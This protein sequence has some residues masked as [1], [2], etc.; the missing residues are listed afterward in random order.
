[1]HVLQGSAGLHHVADTSAH[2]CFQPFHAT[3]PVEESC[4]LLII[5]SGEVHRQLIQQH[6]EHCTAM[7]AARHH[8]PAHHINLQHT[9]HQIML[10]VCHTQYC[11]DDMSEGVSSSMQKV[12]LPQYIVD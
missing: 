9:K 11:E 3:A 8:S 5:L 10:H 4:Q 7:Q 12:C 1:M 2:P 6:T